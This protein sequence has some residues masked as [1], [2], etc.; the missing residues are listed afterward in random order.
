MNRLLDLIDTAVS[1]VEAF[2]RGA[3]QE[4]CQHHW[5]PAHTSKGPARYCA[6][7]DKTEQLTVQM[8]Y[9]QFGTMP[10]KWY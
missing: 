8:F 1:I 10:H 5:R 6:A 7:C 9:A 3:R 2:M 4:A